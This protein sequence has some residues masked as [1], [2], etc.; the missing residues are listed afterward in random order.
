MTSS[1]L[2]ILKNPAILSQKTNLYFRQNEQNFK[3]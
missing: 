2:I 3:K 1:I